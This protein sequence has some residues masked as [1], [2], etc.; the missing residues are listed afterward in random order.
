MTTQNQAVLERLLQAPAAIKRIN[1]LLKAENVIDAVVTPLDNGQSIVLITCSEG[2]G[3]PVAT[4][5]V[6]YKRTALSLVLFQNN[7]NLSTLAFPTTAEI[8]A[9]AITEGGVTIDA[10]SIDISRSTSKLLIVATTDRSIR[11]EGEARFALNGTVTE[12]EDGEE[13][14][15]LKTEPNTPPESVALARAISLDLPATQAEFEAALLKDDLLTPLADHITYS[16][17]EYVVDDAAKTIKLTVVGTVAAD[18]S[19]SEFVCPVYIGDTSFRDYVAGLEL[20]GD[21]TTRVL[22]ISVNGGLDYN[23]LT[24]QTDL[25]TQNNRMF[26]TTVFNVGE[27]KVETIDQ[28]IASKTNFDGTETPYTLSCDVLITRVAGV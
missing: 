9:D 27:H 19:V 18:D 16:K 6:R 12:P 17:Y 21:N 20:A 23:Y 15:P 28:L 3:K 7:I 8:V 5:Q 13:E 24:S 1:P 10:K 25:G 26:N 14:D 4:K 2:E 11:F 22:G